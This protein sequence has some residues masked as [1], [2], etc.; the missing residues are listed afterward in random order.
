M[1]VTNG[2]CT[3]ADVKAAARI[4]DAVDDALI[5]IA[6]EAASR[7]IDGVCNR[8]FYSTSGTRVYQNVDSFITNTD[9]IISITTLK[10]SDDGVIYDTTWTTADYQ[11][12]PLNGVSGGLVQP[13]TRIRAIGDYLFPVWSVTGTYGNKASVQI[14]GVF[15]WSA[16]PTAVRQACILLAMRHWKRYDSP[17][18]VAGFGDIGA[19]RVGRTDPDVQALLAPFM[20]T[21]SS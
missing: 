11:L 16:V 12:E 8:V 21:V 10:T 2:Y 19:I 5:E 1:S 14:A 3:L 4:T 18:G 7:E 15:G 6:I 9:D 20:K 17:L 13:F